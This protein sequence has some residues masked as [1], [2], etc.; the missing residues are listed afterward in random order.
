MNM[1]AKTTVILRGIRGRCPKCG[2]GSL[3]QS[4]LKLNS[5]CPVCAENFVTL[6]ADDGPAWLT[7]ILIGHVAVPLAIYLAMSEV[8]PQAM[9]LTFLFIV[10]GGMAL[11]LLPRAKGVFVGMLWWLRQNRK[12]TTTKYDHL[13]KRP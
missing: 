9:A 4:Y 12:V 8:L 6:R 5:A 2:Q 10:I 11:L 13:E 3:Y 7:I 1:V